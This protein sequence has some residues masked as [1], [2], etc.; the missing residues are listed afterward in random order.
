MAGALG[1]RHDNEK[2]SYKIV[3][4]NGVNEVAQRV[5]IG[6]FS[7]GSPLDNVKWDA[8]DVQQ[9]SATVETYLFYSGGLAG[10]LLATCTVT[11]VAA[12][13]ADLNSVVWS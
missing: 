8:L 6:G 10:T 4:E 7:V 2:Q 1:S 9:T 11:Y 3:S 5:S 13:K 12:D